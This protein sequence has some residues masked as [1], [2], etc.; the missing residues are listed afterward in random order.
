MNKYRNNKVTVDG[1][2]FDSVLESQRYLVLK[3]AQKKGIIQNLELQKKYTLCAKRAG[4]YRNERARYYIADFAYTRD[5][6]LTVEDVKGVKTEAYKLKRAWMLDRYG[7]SI[8]EVTKDN[9]G[10]I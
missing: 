1:I 6:I 3:D 8:R 7:V 9:V 4:L 5:G 10:I 2:K